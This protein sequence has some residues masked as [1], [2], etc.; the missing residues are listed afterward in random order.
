MQAGHQVLLDLRKADVLQARWKDSD[1]SKSIIK[2]RSINNVI[3]GWLVDA[4][5]LF[6][7]SLPSP[8]PPHHSAQPFINDAITPT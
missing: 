5:L 3:D 2:L 8:T 6:L 4:T 1:K 7:P